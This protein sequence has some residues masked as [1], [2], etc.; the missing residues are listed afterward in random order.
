MNSIQKQNIHA[1]IDNKVKPALG[2]AG[3]WSHAD[4]DHYSCMECEDNTMIPCD[5][6]DELKQ[7]GC[8][9]A[10]SCDLCH[11]LMCEDC[12]EKALPQVYEENNG[13]IRRTC[14]DCTQH[15]MFC[16]KEHFFKQNE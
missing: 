16:N 5:H 11:L 14:T 2:A 3:W 4:Y 8:F 12:A 15:L 7:C 9:T 6:K 1:T 10:K 13:H